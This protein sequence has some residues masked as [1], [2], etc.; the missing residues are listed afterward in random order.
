[1][2]FA[3][4][5]LGEREHLMVLLCLPFASAVAN[6]AGFR[7]QPAALRTYITLLAAIGCFLKPHYA[8]MP[9]LLL[10]AAA[11]ARRSW[12]PLRSLE[13]RVVLLAAAANAALVTLL[14]PDW[15]TVARWAA[16]LCQGYGRERGLDQQALFQ[17]KG[18]SVVVP[19]LASQVLIYWRV[20]AVRPLLGPF[21]LGAGYFCLAYAAQQ[22]GWYYHFIP[23]I[24]FAWAGQMLALPV[25][26]T[27]PIREGRLLGGVAAAVL[28]V[29]AVTATAASRGMPTAGDLGGLPRILAAE[30]AGEYVYVFSWELSPFLP[31]VPLAGLN[32]ASRYS[33]LWPLCEF[34][35]AELGGSAD[36]ARLER[37]YQAPLAAAVSEDFERR[38]PGLVIVDRTEP[39]DSLA[40]LLADRRFAAL[41]Q[42][43]V[44]IG[45]VKLRDGPPLYTLYRRIPAPPAAE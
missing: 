9:F 14:Y 10:G 24:L 6:R 20:R 13:M 12:E 32:W 33:S 22:K 18:I 16:D 29:L 15:F 34:A 31:A 26:V 41:W 40:F 11:W 7:A 19:A 44:E 25:C 3:G 21:L 36:A 42:G 1:L 43:Y 30:P 8:A 4:H 17:A 27:A 45:S 23:V 38:H 2:F 28:L 5:D 37:A 35:R 39:F